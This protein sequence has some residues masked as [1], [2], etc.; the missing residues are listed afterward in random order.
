MSEPEPDVLPL[1]SVVTP[2]FN[3]SENVGP[4]VEA[5]QAALDGIAH[6]IIV[7]DD[8]SPDRTWAVAGEIAERDPRVR[9]IRRFGDPGL[10]PAVM[11]GLGSARGSVLAVIDADLQHDERILPEMV[12]RIT[13]DE[14]DV[15][16]GTRASAGGSYGEWGSGR[17]L[18]SWVA[19][20]IARLF[21]RVPTA[22][23]MSGFFA[24]SRS[25]FDEMAPTI[26]PQGFKIL[27]EFI[28]RRRP[29]LRVSE[30]GFTFRNRLHGETK[31]S[32]SV[33][34]SYL[35]A[36]VELRLGRQVKGQFVLYSL[37]G[38]SGVLVNL[39]VFSIADAFDL[40][41]ID[42]GFGRPLR[43]SLLLG[44]AVSIVWNFVL[45]NYFT[46]WE[47]RFRR[48]RLAWGFVQF[49]LVSALGVVVHVSVFQFLQSG[50]WGDSL[51]GEELTRIVHDGA[52][53]LVALVSNYFLNINVIWRRRPVQ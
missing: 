15:V 5:V 30:V 53:F 27:L 22:D 32:P 40:G 48:R 35:L 7:V 16:V 41:D 9:V 6:E 12:R 29:G 1:V 10:S 47:R 17:R 38:A 46:F 28:G 45:N 31:M 37:V 25:V 36:V 24:V 3:E 34:R 18:V 49:T 19:T 43:W 42:I 52:G 26:N 8:D 39:V 33:I 11:A 4:L 21:L 51:L 23:P 2:T 14:A 20:L 50:G 44:I 13:D